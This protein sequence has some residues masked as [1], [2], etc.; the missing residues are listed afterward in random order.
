MQKGCLAGLDAKLPARVK[1]TTMVHGVFGGYL[2]SKVTCH[3]C[4]AESSVHEPLLD[5]SLEVKSAGSVH[6]ALRQFT[7]PELLTRQNRYRCEACSSLADATKQFK[8]HS[9]P[10]I[11]TV[12][13]KRFQMHMQ[14]MTKIHRDVDFTPE[15]DLTPFMSDDKAKV[16]YD[17][18]AVLVHEGQSCHSGHY[19]CFVKGSS[20]MWYAMNDE[21]VHQVSLGTVLRQKAYI[22]FYEK[23]AAVKSVGLPAAAEKTRPAV[24]LEMTR[25]AV[26]P[27]KALGK[28]QV[29]EKVPA[30]VPVSPKKAAVGPP[31]AMKPAAAGPPAAVKPAAATQQAGKPP[32][33][34]VEEAPA[35]GSIVSKSMWQ[36]RKFLSDS[37]ARVFPDW[38]VTELKK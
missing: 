29:P 14:G 9:A 11:L 1:E 32:K 31:A 27:E 12:Q 36:L 22:L 23:R 18:Y 20:G 7:A 24:V 35:Q 5:L 3:S 28:I 15:L 21:R 26:V 19:F 25:P 16:L 33:R 17:L 38:T 34:A 10:N 13:L 30:R 2:Q 8:V 6:A 4:R 37:S